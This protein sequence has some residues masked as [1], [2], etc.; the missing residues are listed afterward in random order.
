MLKIQVWPSNFL[1]II[2]I[3]IKLWKVWGLEWN[4]DLKIFLSQHAVGLANRQLRRMVCS[5]WARF[6]INVASG[7]RERAWH[8][9]VVTKITLMLL[10]KMAK[11]SKQAFREIVMTMMTMFVS[12]LIKK[13]T[14]ISLWSDAW[15]AE[16][17]WGRTSTLG[18]KLPA[19]T[20]SHNYL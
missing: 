16:R 4:L 12:I 18:E 7:E 19:A 1:N 20:R 3:I 14:R 10:M 5:P 9:S 11:R 15:P 17:W 6:S 8:Q 2:Q 13:R